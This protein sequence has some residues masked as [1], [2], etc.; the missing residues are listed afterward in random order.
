MFGETPIFHVKVWNHPI[1][2][3]IKKWLFGVPG[4][5]WTTTQ[6]YRDYNKA[7][8]RIPEPEPIS[9]L[10]GQISSR[11]HTTDFPQMVV[12]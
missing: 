5:K 11:P 6:L 4:R 8:I 1:K 12:E 3:T 10:S 7:I 2:T 9:I